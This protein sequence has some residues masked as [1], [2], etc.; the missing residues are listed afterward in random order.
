MNVTRVNCEWD[1][2]LNGALWEQESE[3]RVD[4][5]QA[6]IDCG[7]EEPLEELEDEGLVT[8]ESEKVR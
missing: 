5:A 7:I 8:F 2:G 6:L 4:V 1:I 3:A